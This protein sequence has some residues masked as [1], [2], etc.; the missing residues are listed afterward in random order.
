[1]TFETIKK[2]CCP[3]DHADLNLHIINQDEDDVKEGFF[4]CTDCKRIYPFVNGVPIMNQDEYRNFELER[5]L[6]ERYAQQYDFLLN[7]D[8]RVEFKAIGA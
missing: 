4:I 2:L 5:P 3:F 1:M 6:L 8:F 7:A